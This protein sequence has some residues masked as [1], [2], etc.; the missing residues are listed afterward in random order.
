MGAK[1]SALEH[2]L[3]CE[4]HM[5]IKVLQPGRLAKA[6]SGEHRFLAGTVRGPKFFVINKRG[7]REQLFQQFRMCPIQDRVKESSYT[8]AAE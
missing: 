5:A 3:V 1:F 8:Q 7:H 6:R 4:V 2:V